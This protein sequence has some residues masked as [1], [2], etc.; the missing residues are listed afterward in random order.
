MAL[1]PQEMTE[2]QI[3][4]AMRLQARAEG[5]VPKLPPAHPGKAETDR[6]IIPKKASERPRRFSRVREKLRIYMK[7]CLSPTIA[8]HIAQETGIS[9][10]SVRRICNEFVAE[11]WVKRSRYKNRFT[12]RAMRN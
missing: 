12:F 4:L 11:G 7:S 3:G 6:E 8:R 10:E 5:H 9:P 2:E 1:L